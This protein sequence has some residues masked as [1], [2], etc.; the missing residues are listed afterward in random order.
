MRD[1]LP[2]GTSAV[3]PRRRCHIGRGMCEVPHLIEQRVTR[4]GEIRSNQRLDLFLQRI[5][6]SGEKLNLGRPEIFRRIRDAA[7]QAAG[8]ER[9]AENDVAPLPA[10]RATIPYLSEP[11]YCCAEPTTQ[12]LV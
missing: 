6:N 12:Q 8:L 1:R 5:V 10:A 2:L 11:W 3:N 7:R 4:S 9:L